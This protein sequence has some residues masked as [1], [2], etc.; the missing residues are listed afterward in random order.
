MSETASR[1]ELVEAL[2]H[3]I[4]RQRRLDEQMRRTRVERRTLRRRREQLLRLVGQLRQERRMY[5]AERAAAES[6]HSL[7]CRDQ[8][9]RHEELSKE[10]ARVSLE[11]QQYRNRGSKYWVA[12]FDRFVALSRQERA[13][14]RQHMVRRLCRNRKLLHS[15]LLRRGKLDGMIDSTPKRRPLAIRWELELL[16]EQAMRL[17]RELIP[18]IVA[19][20]QW[21]RGSLNASPTHEPS[22]STPDALLGQYLKR[23]TSGRL[24]SLLQAGPLRIIEDALG[25]LHDLENSPV[26]EQYLVSLASQLAEAERAREQGGE[27]RTLIVDDPSPLLNAL[28]NDLATVIHVLDERASSGQ[29]ILVLLKDDASVSA[30]RESGIAVVDLASAATSRPTPAEKRKSRPLRVEH[31]EQDWWPD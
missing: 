14:T 25:S 17:R 13:Q 12:A 18:R 3:E 23:L 19:L 20:G 5:A 22:E 30:F 8:H 1:E 9:S 11:I 26:S 7:A 15:L 21:D 29:P 28:H 10:R 27:M 2:R 6:Q 4:C 31:A 16:K 24:V